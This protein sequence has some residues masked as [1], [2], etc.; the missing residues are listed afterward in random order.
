MVG[1]PPFTIHDEHVFVRSGGEDDG[2]APHAVVVRILERNSAGA[3]VVERPDH[4]HGASVGKP[5]DELGDALVLA[6]HRASLLG[7][8]QGQQRHSSSERQ[9]PRGPN[10]EGDGMGRGEP[11][12][13]PPRPGA[14][15]CRPPERG[16]HAR[17][18]PRGRWR[19]R[20]ERRHGLQSIYGSP[21]LGRQTVP[22]DLAVQRLMDSRI[23]RVHAWS[24]N[25]RNSASR[26]R[27]TRI[28]RVG[29]RTPVTAAIS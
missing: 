16:H 24:S 2:G 25:A 28:F 29:M 13:Q 20:E 5:P 4:V 7:R 9:A 11:T 15:R 21:Q 17:L 6:E 26:A 12:H 19:R 8:N 18:E 10:S 1:D 14:R 23:D 3:P 27:C 22:R